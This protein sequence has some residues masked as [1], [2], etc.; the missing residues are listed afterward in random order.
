MLKLST[1]LPPGALLGEARAEL[2]NQLAGTSTIWLSGDNG[3]LETDGASGAVT[4]WTSVNGAVRAVPSQP[5]TG[6]SRTFV[7]D[8][9][10]GLATRSGENCGMVLSHV[11]PDATNFSFAVIYQPDAEAPAMTLL[12]LNTGYQVEKSRDANYL[13]LSDDGKDLTVKDT[14][15]DLHVQTPVTSPSDRPRMLIVTLAG[16]R[17]SIAENLGAPVISQG[18]RPLLAHPADLFIGCRSHRKGLQKTLGQSTILDVFFWPQSTLLLPR[19]ESDGALSLALRR[20][21]LWEF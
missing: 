6:N 3:G 11:T 18:A 21:F 8:G 15:L 19:S 17:L 14:N 10:K 5:N 12:T 4:G 9:R 7:V 1:D 16:D 2:R 20:Y 13:F